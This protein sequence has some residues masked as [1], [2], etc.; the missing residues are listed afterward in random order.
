MAITIQPLAL[1]NAFKI[2]SD[3]DVDATAENNVNDGAATIYNIDID[4]VAAAVTYVKL[5]N[6]AT[7]PI[8]TTAPDIIIPVAA[9]IRRSVVITG[10]VAFATGLSFGA[11]TTAGTA[12]TTSPAS[13]VVLEVVVA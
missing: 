9:S 3:A 1:G 13:S 4:N 8:G 11:V 5:Y 2:I 10:G 7:T 12:G 6:V